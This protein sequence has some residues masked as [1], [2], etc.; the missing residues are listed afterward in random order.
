MRVHARLVRI[1]DALR[2]D[3]LAV[4][5]H[6]LDTQHVE[7]RV[8]ILV[9]DAVLDDRIHDEQ[10]RQL[11]EQG[12]A[13]GEGVDPALLVQLLLGL[14]GFDAVA[15][16][17]LLDLAHLRL[18][19]L[20]PPLRHQL[21]PEERDQDPAHDERQHDD[22]PA[23]RAREAEAPEEVVDR[24]QDDEQELEDRRE[25]PGQ[26]ADRV[27]A[28]LGGLQRRVRGRRDRVARGVDAAAARRARGDQDHDRGDQ[29][30]RPDPGPPGGNRHA[31]R[32]SSA[33]RVIT[34]RI[35]RMAACDPLGAHPA[36]A[37]EA[38]FLDGL[39][40]VVGARRLEP[41]ALRA[42]TRTRSG[43]A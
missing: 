16:E 41:T 42:A 39:L 35:P 29:E 19:H 33:N 36:A 4:D 24:G 26:Q 11:E 1:D 6:D 37:Q 8:R 25:Q 32:A 13:A 12:Q 14:L 3:V 40:G 23:D 5:R 28:G 2:V 27:R 31:M 38:V 17:A 20:D 10:Q 9:G 30:D 43:R 18:E 21:Q 15:L 7:H 34:A 22:R